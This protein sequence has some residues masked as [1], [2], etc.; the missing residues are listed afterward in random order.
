MA[1]SATNLASYTTAENM[2]KLVDALRRKNNVE[3]EAKPIFGMGDSAFRNAK[4]ALRTLGIIEQDTTMFTG[5]GKNLSYAKE[6]DKPIELLSLI[7]KY[8]PYESLLSNIFQRGDKE[9]DVETIVGFWGRFN[10]GTTERNRKD[11]SS[12]FG[13]IVEYVG[14]GKFIRGRG[15]SLTRIVWN[16]HAAERLEK[17]LDQSPEVQGSS[18]EGGLDTELNSDGEQEIVNVKPQLNPYPSE[19]RSYTTVSSPVLTPAV[20]IAV[21]MT[22]WPEPQIKNFF[23]WMY[24]RFNDND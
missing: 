3:D 15:D 19:S 5:P 16:A 17:G 1:N 4:S 8:N 24:G 18:N 22:S 21:D 11:A 14:L 6:A 2:L 23:Q 7:C 20:N 10:M 13:N 9:T 12:L